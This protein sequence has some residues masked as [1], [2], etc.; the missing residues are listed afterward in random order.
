ME[1][2]SSISCR[3]SHLIHSNGHTCPPSFQNKPHTLLTHWHRRSPRILRSHPGCGH[4]CGTDFTFTLTSAETGDPERDFC[5]QNLQWELYMYAPK[6]TPPVRAQ[7]SSCFLQGIRVRAAASL[8]VG[9]AGGGGNGGEPWKEVGTASGPEPRS[10]CH[11]LP[12]VWTPGWDAHRQ[13]HAN[14]PSA[15]SI[16][17]LGGLATYPPGIRS[18]GLSHRDFT[19]RLKDV[20]L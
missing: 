12:R 10:L 17:D 15:L 2:G 3:P 5:A 16:T 19:T 1:G 11:E 13:L 9:Q 20:C 6:H 18:T 14:S 4:E 8:S 7:L